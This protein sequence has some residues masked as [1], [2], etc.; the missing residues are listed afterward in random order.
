MRSLAV[1]RED[2]NSLKTIHT[3]AFNTLFSFL[4]LLLQADLPWSMSLLMEGAGT[5]IQQQQQQQR[6]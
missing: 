3:F 5:D 2:L 1:D 4:F 6:S